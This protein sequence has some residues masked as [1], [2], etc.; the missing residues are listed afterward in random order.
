[1][2]TTPT[3]IHLAHLFYDILIAHAQAY[4]G[5]AI[6]YKDLIGTAKV[7]H[8]NDEAVQMS[9]PVSLGRRLELIVQFTRENQLPPLTCVVVNDTG[10]P[11]SSY[12]NIHGSW[13]ADLDAVALYDWSAWAGRWNLFVEAEKKKTVPVKRRTDDA[14]RQL[15]HKE[16]QAGNLPRL[17]LPAKEQL[18]EFLKDGLPFEDA[19][20]ELLEMAQA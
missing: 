19:Y 6:R 20:A 9:I 4:P 8:P 16:F 15:V 1:M 3:D 10:R 12:K 7:A 13:E 11:G 2:K 14:A 5:K 17:E 18:V